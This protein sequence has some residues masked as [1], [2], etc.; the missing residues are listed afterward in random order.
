MQAAKPL[1]AS[2]SAISSLMELDDLIAGHLREHA[3]DHSSASD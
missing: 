3:R 1:R 2:L